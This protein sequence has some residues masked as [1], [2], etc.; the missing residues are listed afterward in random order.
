[1]LAWYHQAL[2]AVDPET[3]TAQA[4]AGWK[5][6][7]PTVIA[8]GKAGAAMCRGVARSVGPVTGVC[9]A[10]SHSPTPEGIELLLGDHPIP[11]PASFR[12]GKRVLEVAAEATGVCLALISGGG[13]AL[14]EH[15]RP[16]IAEEFMS[17]VTS[18][19]IDGG[20]TIAEINLVRSHLSA[21][22]GG[23]LARAAAAPVDTY[24]LSDVGPA[25]PEV[26]ASGPTVAIP[27]N[28][29]AAREVLV[30]HGIEVDERTWAA[31]STPGA[32]RTSRTV[33][34][35]ADG[36]TAAAA[37]VEAARRDG[38]DASLVEEW[39]S[40]SVDDCLD[41]FLTE[42]GSGATVAAGEPTVVVEHP[43]KGGRNTH[44]ALLAAVRLAGSE[45]VFAAMATDGVD[46]RSDAAGAIVDGS[47][48]T[49]GGD[50]S[51][52]LSRFSSADYL[53][54][55]GDLVRTGPSNTNVADLWLLWSR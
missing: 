4:L 48:L 6:P 40:G 20:A 33:N 22:K 35:L 38:L 51:P 53:E 37:V 47:T 39:L 14:C 28:P 43:G 16:G 8:I 44:A 11:G 29:E 41:R 15:P 32:D 17:M 25:P 52:Y 10:S 9:V 26:I 34:V 12:A 31:M 54:R 19:L 2:A 23:G 1:M 21:I 42:A 24:L 46:G 49:R 45:R 50:P 3:L 18:T 55:S 7:P 27:T 5:G 30:R 36:L 13:S